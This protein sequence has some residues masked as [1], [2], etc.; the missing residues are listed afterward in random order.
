MNTPRAARLRRA[1]LSIA[2]AVP[3]LVLASPP[4]G[5]PAD[6]WRRKAD[7][8]TRPGFTG[9]SGKA[10]N[11][12]Y[13]VRSGS[14]DRS[15]VGQAAEAASGGSVRGATGGEGAQVAERRAV[16]I[17]AG[18]VIGA[19]IGAELARRMDR[20][21]RSCVGHALELAELRASVQWT[22]PN[23]RVTYQ[24]TPLA[25]ESQRDGCRRFRLIA[26]GSFGLSEGHDVACPDTA[27]V[28]RLAEDRLASRR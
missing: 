16:A 28:W 7:P 26:H 10:W 24:V 4:T 8:P 21:D 19:V 25:D 27:G 23:T 2:A 9:Y 6:G 18:T 11:S 15:R 22:N 5:A 20:A 13:G 17:A 1:V 14:C 3:C 12:D